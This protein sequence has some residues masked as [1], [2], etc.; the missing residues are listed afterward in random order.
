MELR[1]LRYFL[2]VAEE[3]HFG[4]AAEKLHI[5]QS[6][7]SMQ[8]Q[9]LEQ[10]LGGK[11]LERTSRKVEL[12]EAGQLFK[13]SAI[14]ILEQADFAKEQA[15]RALQGEL[16]AVRIAMVGNACM[17]EQFIA[18]L[19]TFH[20]HYPDVELQ[21][22]ELSTS[23][24]L[25]KLLN[26]EIDIGYTPFYQ[27]HEQVNVEEIEQWT[28]YLAL[29]EHHP[30]AAQETVRL[31]Q[32]RNEPFIMYGVKRLEGLLNQ[33]LGQE[34]HIA[35]RATTPMGVLA[36]VAS[37]LGVTVIADKLTKFNKKGVVTLPLSLP[38]PLP[39]IGFHRISRKE[40]NSPAVEAFLQITQQ[41]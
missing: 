20:Q 37:G 17:S 18:D 24:Q 13:A 2:T 40:Y 19:K 3:G 16:G 36:L 39:K 5:V 26:N 23:Q 15:Q 34:I 31:E 4:R 10:E 27:S 30:L 22:E 12:T 38:N 1:H 8:I 32:L 35:H 41:H 28:I 14:R 9:A 29:P 25:Q 11:L 7:L 33:A 21:I 6:A